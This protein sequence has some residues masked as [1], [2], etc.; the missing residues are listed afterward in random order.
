MKTAKKLS[1]KNI[2][3]ACALLLMITSIASVYA[4]EGD[5]NQTHTQEFTRSELNSQVPGSNFGQSW[6]REEYTV[7]NQK[8]NH[9]Q[10]KH[11]NKYRNKAS[12]SAASSM[13]RM[14]T[15]DRYTQGSAATGS[16]NRQNTASRSISGGRYAV[17]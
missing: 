12:S 17:F 8:Q 9:N 1:A 5:I 10:Y 3:S 14:N 15:T 16:M 7:M 11:S 6:N 13:N 2:L 4:D